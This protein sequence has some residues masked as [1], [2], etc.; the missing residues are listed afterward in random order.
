MTLPL[1]CLARV[2]AGVVVYLSRQANLGNRFATTDPSA[3]LTGHSDAELD[4][5]RSLLLADAEHS[6]RVRAEDAERAATRAA[7]DARKAGKAAPGASKA[8]PAPSL[9][10]AVAADLGR[11]A[12][13]PLTIVPPSPAEVPDGGLR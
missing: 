4:H 12:T 1:R 7:T 11:Y 10:D 13:A 9:R 5:W 3:A 2:E 8:K 6:D